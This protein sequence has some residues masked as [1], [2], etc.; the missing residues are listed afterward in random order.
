[1][2]LGTIAHPSI[3]LLT[4]QGREN[5]RITHTRPFAVG[6]IAVAAGN[7]SNGRKQISAA[8]FVD[9]AHRN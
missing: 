2:F 4:I 8:L 7:A 1:M 6:S 5:F 9:P 3:A